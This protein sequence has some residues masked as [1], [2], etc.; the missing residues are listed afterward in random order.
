[1]LKQINS[2]NNKSILDSLKQSKFIA[3]IRQIKN[4]KKIW[5][6]VISVII[7]V[8]IVGGGVYWWQGPVIKKYLA[9]I[10]GKDKIS[11]IGLEQVD[12]ETFQ[13]FSDKDYAKDKNHIYINVY[14]EEE[15]G[16]KNYQI[17]QG[18][19]VATF[20]LLGND[21]FRDKN[22][23]YYNT[24]RY[25]DLEPCIKILENVDIETV[26]ILSNRCIK[27]KNNVYCGLS[28]ED[29]LEPKVNMK[30][31]DDADPEIF[32]VIDEDERYFKDKNHVFCSR[33]IS[34]VVGANVQPI[35]KADISSFE[36]IDDKFAKDKNYVFVGCRKLENSDSKTF[37]FL[38]NSAFQKDK[39][40]VYSRGWIIEDADSETFEVIEDER[41]FKDNEHIFYFC[42]SCPRAKVELLEEADINSFEIID[43]KIARDKN[44][45]FSDGQS[46]KIEPIKYWLIYE[47]RD[48]NIRLRYP[49]DWGERRRD[50]K[51]YTKE[52]DYNLYRGFALPLGPSLTIQEVHPIEFIITDSEIET[53][54]YEYTKTIAKRDDKQYIL[55]GG[56]HFRDIIETMAESLEFSDEVS[57]MDK[58]IPFSTLDYHLLDSKD[59]IS[60]LN[61]HTY[62]G[63]LLNTLILDK[64]ARELLT[65]DVYTSD[66]LSKLKEK[67]TSY[68]RNKI[69]LDFYAIKV[70][71][72]EKGIDVV[73]GYLWPEGGGA[74]VIVNNSS[75]SLYENIKLCDSTVT[76]GEVT[77]C[78]ATLEEGGVKWSCFNLFSVDGAEMKNWLFSFDGSEPEVWESIEKY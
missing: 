30:V 65:L 19:D 71:N 77:P 52:S 56:Y 16:V 17:A 60:I 48:F 68:I 3:I 49:N 58:L 38:K 22:Y 57:P 54:N 9:E 34:K 61:C 6:I 7:A 32:E 44:Y 66:Y 43:N 42:S 47:N 40:N 67:I 31:V 10:V 13:F 46:R 20:E 37:Q 15:D 72:L 74:V 5:L 51:K 63:D 33:G 75:V 28:M 24:S 29:D 27:D 2:Q 12:I 64:E 50:V 35:E 11:D 25:K 78:N 4:I 36:I 26:V 76:G 53:H 70:C 62:G 55:A 41:Y 69:D 59:C 1:M 45:L 21:Y 18:V 14:D 8:L 73:A 23:V 39:N